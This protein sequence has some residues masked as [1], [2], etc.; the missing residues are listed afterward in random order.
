M[1]LLTGFIAG[2]YPALYVSSFS[3]VNVLKGATIFRGSGKLSSVLLTLQFSISVMALVMGIV[4]AKNAE[5]QRTLDRGYDRDNIIVVPVAN[6]YF[7]SFRNEILSNPK[8]ISAEGTQNHIGFGNYRRPIKDEEK[9]LEVDVMDIGPEYAKTM[10]L[11]LVEG[12][13]FDELRAGC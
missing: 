11:R 13:L 8:V 4:F 7:T 12:R 5:Y 2:V 1:L 9:Q 6:E 3:P 10:G